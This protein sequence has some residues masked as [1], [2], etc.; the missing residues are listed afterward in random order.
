MKNILI[1]LT[2]TLLFTLTVN[3]QNLFF[4][5]ENSYPCTETMTLKSNSD[6][7]DDLN[8]LLAKD[9]NTGLFAVSTE[10]YFGAIFSEKLIIY[11]DDGTVITCNDRKASDYVDERAKAVYP[12][13]GYQLNKLKNSNIHTVRYTLETRSDQGL[14]SDME[15]N[16]SASK[17]GVQTKTIISDFL[18]GKITDTVE[19]R[20]EGNKGVGTGAAEVNIYGEGGGTGT[21]GISYDLAGRKMI[22]HVKPKHEIQ[23]EGIVV[24]DITVDRNGNVTK[25]TAGVRGSTTLE[26]YFLRVAME[27]AM[28]TKFDRKPDAPKIQKGTIT[29]YFILR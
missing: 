29:Y 7:A 11:L 27:A 13:T 26:E 18:E 6:D 25:A 24:V 8:I 21:D 14:L 5:G 15:W 28:A 20:P 19:Y 22:Y 4:I 1:V 10:S 17:K 3:G 12:L 23:N 16:W 9:G 2:A